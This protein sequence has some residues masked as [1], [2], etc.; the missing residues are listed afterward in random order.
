MTGTS[1]RLQSS[2]ERPD[3]FQ[4]CHRPD[5]HA[6]HQHAEK[7]VKMPVQSFR[8]SRE[9]NLTL[10]FVPIASPTDGPLDRIG[11]DCESL[12]GSL[13]WFFG[14]FWLLC[15]PRT[16]THTHTHTPFPGAA[17]GHSRVRRC[18]FLVLGPEY[19]EE[20][21]GKGGYRK[22]SKRVFLRRLMSCNASVTRVKQ[23]D[24]RRAAEDLENWTS[25]R[26]PAARFG[27]TRIWNP[28]QDCYQSWRLPH[29]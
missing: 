10:S 6:A 3:F 9:A 8:T 22:E 19:Q 16:L 2:P 26:G 28:S 23:K 7:G 1:I 5:R 17:I 20:R 15:Q 18:L 12:Q 4:T 21:R 27:Y 14:G 24:K 29:L 11:C 25:E 13:G